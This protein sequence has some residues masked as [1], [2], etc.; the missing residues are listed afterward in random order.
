MEKI[1][2]NKA[3]IAAVVGATVVTVAGIV[4]ITKIVNKRRNKQEVQMKPTNYSGFCLFIQG[5]KLQTL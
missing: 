3:K 5:Q 1:K 2:E 4:G